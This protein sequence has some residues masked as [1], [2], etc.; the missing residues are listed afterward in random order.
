M[1]ADPMDDEE[2]RGYPCLDVH[3]CAGFH[4]GIPESF[5]RPVAGSLIIFG[6]SGVER[7][8]AYLMDVLRG[9]GDASRRSRSRFI[10]FI[11]DVYFN[12]VAPV[13]PRTGTPRTI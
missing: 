5:A 9:L 12:L 3:S 6:L 1:W 11:E 8:L 7:G 13:S 2:G 4:Q 10:D